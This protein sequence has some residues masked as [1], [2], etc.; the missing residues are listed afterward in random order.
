M[1]IL[2]PVVKLSV[3]LWNVWL[4][5]FPITPMPRLR[6]ERI[7]PLLQGHDVVVLNEAFTYKNLLMREAGYNYSITLDEERWLPWKFRFVDS[8]LLVLSKYPFLKVEKEMFKKR[9]GSDRFSSKGVIMVQIIVNGTEID[10]YATHMQAGKSSRRARQRASQVQQLAKFINQH[11]GSADNSSRHVIVT[12]D[13]NMG[14]ITDFD[15]FN[16]AYDTWEDKL[17]RTAEYMRLKDLTGLE[18]AVYEHPY[19]QQDINRFLVRNVEGVV[20]NIGKPV[21]LING[22]RVHLSDSERYQFFAEISRELK[23][24]KRNRQAS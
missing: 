5:P 23:Q 7:S 10:V 12:G 2:D 24:E 9:A 19:W 8:G 16:W 18:D 17:D 6:A 20:R 14:P 4:L 13:M 21:E 11:S 3:I 1:K 15:C 22:K